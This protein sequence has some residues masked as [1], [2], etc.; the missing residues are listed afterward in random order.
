[1]RARKACCSYDGVIAFFDEA[2]EV[3]PARVEFVPGD[4]VGGELVVDSFVREDGAIVFEVGEDDAVSGHAVFVCSEEVNV[5]VFEFVTDVFCVRVIA[6]CA[7]PCGFHAESCECN[8]GVRASAASVGV[9]VFN[10]DFLSDGITNVVVIFVFFYFWFFC[11]DKYVDACASNGDDVMHGGT[12]EFG[13]CEHS[14]CSDKDAY[15]I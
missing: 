9:E 3:E 15:K 1:M 12:S 11:F 6:E 2:A 4:V 8:C 10:Q 14:E 13:E 7:S 5:F